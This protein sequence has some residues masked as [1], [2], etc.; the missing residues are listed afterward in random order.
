MD[1]ESLTRS[2][3]RV[4]ADLASR[5][6]GVVARRQLMDAGLSS[7]VIGRRLR[8]GR[9]HQVHLGVYLVGHAVA[10]A[11]AVEQA[12]LLACGDDA[13]LSHRSSAALWKLLPYPASSTACVTILPGRSA[14]RPGIE[15]HRARLTRRDTRRRH[16]LALTSPPRTILDLSGSLD[17]EILEALVG[18]AHY[19]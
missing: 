7:T 1:T 9:L 10:P 13:A 6:H 15:L 11:L 5:Q 2:P 18:E 19:R 14:A 3:D 4:I 12:A 16:G 8:N 17:Q